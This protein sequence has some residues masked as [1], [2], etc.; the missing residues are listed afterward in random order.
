MDWI[1][2]AFSIMLLALMVTRRDPKSF[3]LDSL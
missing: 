3:D 2:L 1:A